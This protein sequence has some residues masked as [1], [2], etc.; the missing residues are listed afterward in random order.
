[1][2][3]PQT[4]LLLLLA[5][6]LLPAWTIGG[7]LPELSH[8]AIALSVLIG[9]L[10]AVDAARL[11]NVLDLLQVHVPPVI[12]LVR[13]RP[14][15]IPVT[16]TLSA[17]S[18]STSSAST[19]AESPSTTRPE[20]M[21]SPTAQWGFLLPPEIVSPH[22]NAPVHWKNNGSARGTM[23]VVGHERGAFN[24][25]TA[26]VQITS[27]LQFWQRRRLYPIRSQIRVQPDL[28]ASLRPHAAFLLRGDGGQRPLRH[29][30]RGREFEKLREYT[31]GDSVEDIH[32]KATA[33]RNHPVTKVFQVERTQ[34]VYVLVDASRLSG[35]R[36]PNLHQAQST[37]HQ[38]PNR[39]PEPNDAPRQSVHPAD[40]DPSERGEPVLEHSIR[41]A[42]VLGAVAERQGDLFGLVTF[43]GQ[44]R[45][46]LRAHKG[47]SHF[48]ACREQL[49]HLQPRPES[50]DFP[51]LASFISARLRR[52]ALLLFLTDLSDATVAASFLRGADIL[53]RRHLVSIIQPQSP[54]AAPLFEGPSVT[55]LG[56][57]HESLA[58][59]LLWQHT[60][61]LRS[62][63]GRRGIVLQTCP[64]DQ[65]SSILVNRYLDVKNRQ[66]L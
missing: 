31:P 4:R 42:L 29:V 59:H 48:N 5:F 16:F 35:R 39:N 22:E 47:S 2:W 50:P 21:T 41:A 9:L 8:V 49:V 20:S 38:P 11:R 1:M 7:I 52:R 43:S 12:R 27:P 23:D 17:D 34:E 10:V 60:R 25:T 28:A 54:G 33:K 19:S 32:W 63:L 13:K 51:E 18:T 57:I 46:F 66:I 61:E 45:A 26:F 3:I 40:D 6:T 44:V 53:R 65:I 56:Q 62:V 58:G 37:K 14:S 64:V 55:S 30:G 24:L 36:L 15:H